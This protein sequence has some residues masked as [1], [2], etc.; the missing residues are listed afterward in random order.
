MVVED[1]RR[2]MEVLDAMRRVVVVDGM[3]CMVE[4]VRSM[5]YSA[6]ISYSCCSRIR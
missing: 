2:V 1:M 3:L 6:A 5:R 4:V